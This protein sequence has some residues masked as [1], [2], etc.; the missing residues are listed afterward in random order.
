M[1]TLVVAALVA[2]ST[3]TALTAPRTCPNTVREGT[4]LER[5]IRYE[6]VPCAP[7]EPL[8]RSGERQY[9]LV[10]NAGGITG[11]CKLEASIDEYERTNVGKGF[12]RR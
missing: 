7:N 3:T 12:R 4:V 8:C 6:S 10:L 1:R 11:D 5:G 9:F 2:A